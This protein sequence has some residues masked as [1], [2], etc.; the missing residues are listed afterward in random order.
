M[1][2]SPFEFTEKFRIGDEEGGD[3]II[4]ETHLYTQ[5]A[6][7]SVNQLFVGGFRVSPVMS[8]SDEGRFIG[9]VGAQGKGP[10]EFGSSRSIVVGP[11]D[12]I[13]SL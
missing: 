3:S 12:S 1:N 2:T 7:N 11:G 13:Y 9:Y 6:V 8:F 4:I 10:G 5:I